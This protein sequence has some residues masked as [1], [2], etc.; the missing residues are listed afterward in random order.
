M[1]L[2][3]FVLKL[4][5]ICL[6][7]SSV[8]SA[9][10]Q[11]QSNMNMQD[12]NGNHTWPAQIVRWKITSKVDNKA[13]NA[14]LIFIA[15]NYSND[16]N[17]KTH[18]QIKNIFSTEKPD[19]YIMEGFSNEQEG[20][21]PKRLQEKSKKLC[22]TGKCNQNLYA[23]YIATKNNVDFLGAELSESEQVKLL[24]KEGFA[25]DDIIFYMLMQQLP[26]FFRD[27]D[28]DRHKQK[29]TK[30][31]YESMCNDFLQR[32]IAGW[33]NKKVNVTYHD[34]LVWWGKNFA[35]P[36]D[37]QK[38]FS[39]FENGFALVEPSNKNDAYITQKIAYYFNKNRQNHLL[40]LIKSEIKT[41]NKV[42]VVFGATHLRDIWQKL[43]D[44][45]GEP[46][47]KV[48]IENEIIAK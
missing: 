12:N 4:S 45:F 33:I 11:E 38:E 32:T 19:L 21:S 34:F 31:T 46:S 36:L 35:K 8:C 43:V 3:N 13:D 25:F 6:F 2:R 15:S 7:F 27:G 48:I 41:H 5:C 47:S 1:T 44:A 24:S 26:Y 30:A 42:V 10:A 18:Q 23:A 29:F 14:E 22:A 37:L 28:F 9:F 40:D 16:A 39:N 17:S 20:L